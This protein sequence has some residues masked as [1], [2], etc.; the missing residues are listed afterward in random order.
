[1]SLINHINLDKELEKQIGG[2]L[3][4]QKRQIGK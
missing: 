1:M 2:N 3:Y 4:N